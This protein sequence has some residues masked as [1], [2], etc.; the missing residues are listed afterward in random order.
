MGPP[1][2]LAAALLAAAA[3]VQAAVVHEEAR[4]S[5]DLEPKSDKKFFKKDYP[6][7]KRPVA[8]HHYVFDHPYPQVQDTGDFDRDFVKDENADGGRWK[9][10][11][12]YDILRGKIRKAEKGL[13]QAKAKLD[14]E[15]AE[16]KSAEERY[17]QT[18]SAEGEASVARKKAEQEAAEAAARVNK[19]EGGSAKK[20][21]KVSGAVGDAVQKVN[22]EM[23]DLEK[24]KKELAAAKKRLKE[25]IKEKEDLDKQEKVH[26]EVKK[27]K[28][29]EERAKKEKEV[30]DKKGQREEAEKEVVKKSSAANSWKKKLA[31][32][33]LEH[34]EA[35]K[36]YEQEQA[37]VSRTEAE[38]KVAEKNLR[39]FRRPPFVDG[40]GGVYN[41]PDDE[42]NSARSSS[43]IAAMLL[44]LL[45]A[46]A[47]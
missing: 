45:A 11:M 15:E 37:D 40:N 39:K 17:S 36:T 3:A 27:K 5:P 42:K 35:S 24:C 22:D 30:K 25:L 1:L 12:E 43:V 9:A 28:A 44:A 8:D 46:A 18:T 33:K 34:A 19:L 21:T 4:I 38:L 10:Q 16:W 29:V 41:V 7:D 26:H 6:W 23:N 2:R 32:E 14:K 47:Q 13:A 20:G 31:E